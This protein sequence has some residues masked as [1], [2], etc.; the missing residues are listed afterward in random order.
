MSV[1]KRNNRGCIITR[2]KGTWF[3]S[4]TI[5][6]QRY[7]KG[8]PGIKTREQAEKIEAIKRQE[9]YEGRYTKEIE[10]M[11]FARFVETVYKRRRKSEMKSF[12]YYES[13]FPVFCKFL[14]KKLLKQIKPVDIEAYRNQRSELMVRGK[15]KLSLSSLNREKMMLSSIFKL[16]VDLDY[17]AVNPCQKVKAYKTTSRR[18]TI[19]R[20]EEETQLLEALSGEY[21]D[22]RQPF[23]LMLHTGMRVS[24]V[25][26]L[27]WEWLHCE[28]A[29]TAKI[30]LPSAQ[31]KN[32]KARTIPLTGEAF[33]AIQEL[34]Q[35]QPDKGKI[36]PGVSNKSINL[37]HRFAAL[38]DRIGL[39]HI[40]SHTLRHTFITRLLEKGAN[41]FAVQE[42]VGHSSLQ[43]LRHYTHF[44]PSYLR[45]TL[46][47]LEKPTHDSQNAPRAL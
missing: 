27:R 23:L 12:A 20:P 29:E 8:L 1:Y 36:F 16:A 33:Q 41:L 30:I 46:K 22:L 18:E 42:M 9:V 7:S 24:E 6:K 15:R 5:D 45:D 2:G 17:I 26:A 13:Y 44:S 39:P 10:P 11:T 40:S 21:E 37:G 19:L 43:M 38:C 35:N 14:G 31:T 3:Y 25:M 4:F 32:G 47:L 34:R 28:E